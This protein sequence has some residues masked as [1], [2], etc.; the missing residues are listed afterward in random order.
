MKEQWIDYV[1]PQNYFSFDRKDVEY[2]EI[3]WWWSN[4]C[5]ETGTIL[6]MGQGIYHMGEPQGW[7][8]EYWQ[9]PEEIANQ[10]KFNQNFDNI[11]GTIFFTYHDFVPGKNPIKDYGL[12]T[13]KKLWNN[14]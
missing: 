8:S 9:N 10:L 2:H 3:A 11:T 13:V 5:K 4:I 6:Y 12:E 1:V 14:K 7:G